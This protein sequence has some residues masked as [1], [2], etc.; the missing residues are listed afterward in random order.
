MD[1]IR[2]FEDLVVWRQARELVND[3]YDLTASLR[4]RRD[5]AL[6]DQINRSA[7]SVMA[8]IAEGFERSGNSEFR[9]FLF[10]AKGSCG[11]LRSHLAVARDQEF[12]EEKK[13]QELQKKVF[14]LSSMIAGFIRYLE[15]S[16]LKG[17]KY[18]DR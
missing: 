14:R 15:Q 9:Q 4:T 17:S 12:I 8:N 6:A 7:I 10:I 3:V 2:T 11:E 16:G 18:R 5:W 1:K 13:Y